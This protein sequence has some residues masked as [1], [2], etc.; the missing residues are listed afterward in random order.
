M[1]VPAATVAVG[2]GTLVDVLGAVLASHASRR[3]TS[4]QFPEAR[5]A[6]RA[7]TERAAFSLAT[8]GVRLIVYI[9]LICTLC[10]PPIA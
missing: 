2:G 3:N 4:S 6:L 9:Q 8:K 7:Q 1:A 5:A 10:T